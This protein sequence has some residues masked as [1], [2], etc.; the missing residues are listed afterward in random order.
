MNIDC[1]NN[2]NKVHIVF[3][4]IKKIAEVIHK[5]TSDIIPSHKTLK[6]FF[7]GGHHNRKMEREKEKF[8]LS[9]ETVCRNKK[10]GGWR[11]KNRGMK[12]HLEKKNSK[13]F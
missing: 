13:E 5:F 11:E 8:F 12:S 4:D 9:R 3:Y 10:N 2:E 7:L 1:Y 6:D